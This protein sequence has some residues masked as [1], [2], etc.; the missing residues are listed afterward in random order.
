MA[1]PVRD[2]PRDDAALGRQPARDPPRRRGLV[3]QQRVRAALPRDGRG[4]AASTRRT[5]TSSCSSCA[6]G[7]A[8]DGCSRPTATG[9]TSRPCPPCAKP[10]TRWRSRSRTPP[11]LADVGYDVFI[12]DAEVIEV[13]R[14]RLHAIHN[15]GHTPG[16]VSLQGRRRSAAVHRR[17][18]VPGRSGQHRVRG[19]RFRHDHRVHRQQA[20][21]VSGRHH[22]PARATA[23][24]PRSGTERPHLQEWVDRGW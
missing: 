4:R 17:H 9:T 13:G 2:W 23:P 7:S 22:H 11:M 20:V 24:T 19:R 1:V 6:A 8:C 14:L 21:H 16:S 3:R 5:S 12:D 18:P 10:A 15:P